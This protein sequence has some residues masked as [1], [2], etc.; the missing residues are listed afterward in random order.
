MPTIWTNLNVSRFILL[1][2]SKSSQFSSYQIHFNAQFV[3]AKKSVPN[4]TRT[5]NCSNKALKSLRRQKE[6]MFKSNKNGLCIIISQAFHSKCYANKIQQF[7]I[8]NIRR[9]RLS[10]CRMLSEGKI[11]PEFQLSRSWERESERL[12]RFDSSFLLV[13]ETLLSLVNYEWNQ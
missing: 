11:R 5:A 3:R 7:K 13:M 12:N 6:Q 8:R 9:M 4:L 2:L 10:G 1:V